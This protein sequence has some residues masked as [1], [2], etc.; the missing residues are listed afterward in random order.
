MAAAKAELEER[1]AEKRAELQAQRPIGQRLDSTRAALERS[2]KRREQ[3][4]QALSLAQAALTA[5]AEEEKN[6]TTQLA[7]LEASVGAEAPGPELC[8]AALGEQLE[9]AVQQIRSFDN[10]DP[11]VG[12]EAQRESETL[13]ARFQ[14]T[15]QAAEAAMQVARANIPR[16]LNGKQP[17]QHRE[18]P[19]IPLDR[20][21][22]KKQRVQTH[23]EAWFTPRRPLA[24]PAASAQPAATPAP[25]AGPPSRPAPSLR[26]PLASPY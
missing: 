21:L 15:L 3:A 20:R 4:E 10:V 13:L 12:E 11:S 7:E 25:A 9:A 18:D 17:L 2:R 24:P 1:L 23:I 14:A 5:A 19:P 6:L 8:M 22:N 16:R 26:A